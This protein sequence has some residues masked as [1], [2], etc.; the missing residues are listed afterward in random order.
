MPQNIVDGWDF[1]SAGAY[2]ASQTLLAGFEE[3]YF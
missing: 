1:A 3:A 2:S